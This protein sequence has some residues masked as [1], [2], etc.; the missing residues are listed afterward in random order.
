MYF[1][2]WKTGY[3]VLGW[4]IC[5]E[6]PNILVDISFYWMKI[7]NELACKACCPRGQAL[8]SFAYGVMLIGYLRYGKEFKCVME[9]G[10][11]K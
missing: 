5:I 10:V 11:L 1:V 4:T 8:R 2:Y 3:V 6:L 7:L 9:I